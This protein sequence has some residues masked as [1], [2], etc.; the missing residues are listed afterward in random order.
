MRYKN[1]KSNTLPHGISKQALDEAIQSSGYP[2]QQIVGH[3]LSELGFYVRH[4]WGFS[5]YSIHK[6]RSAD[7]TANMR[8]FDFKIVSELRVRP[9]LDIIIECKKSFDPYIFFL[10]SQSVLNSRFPLVAGLNTNEIAIHTDDNPSRWIVN[11]IDITGL[12][13]HEFLHME[14]TSLNFTKIGF[15]GGKKPDLSGEEPFNSLLMPLLSAMRAYAKIENPIK[16]AIYFDAHIIMGLAVLD[17]PMYGVKV[18]DRGHTSKPIPWVR[19]YRH[20]PTDDTT[21]FDHSKMVYAIDVVHKDFLNEYLSMHLMPFADEWGK[22][23]LAKQPVLL[24]GKGF[25]PSLGKRWPRDFSSVEPY[26]IPEKAKRFASI[27]KTIGRS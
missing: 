1:P 6:L 5:D 23:V 2:L 21:S 9:Q 18:M 17:A 10:A 4:E 16:T 19:V 27:R 25:I 26:N 22:G 14:Q 24:S 12:Q 15:R 7:L 3:K 20:E 13:D 11:P 8:L